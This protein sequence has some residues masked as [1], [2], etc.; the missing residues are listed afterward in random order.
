M[1]IEETWHGGTSR[2]AVHPNGE[3]RIFGVLLGLE[4]PEECVDLV[5]L[6]LANALQSTWGEVDVASVRLDARRR[7]AK[8][9]LQGVN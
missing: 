4:E 9:R 6:I 8:F 7:L 1:L 5:I 3:R 2:S